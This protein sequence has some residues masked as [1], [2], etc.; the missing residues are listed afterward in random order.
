MAELTAG[1]I[2]RGGRPAIKRECATDEGYGHANRP[3]VRQI[4]AEMREA[5]EYD[6][7]FDYR[8]TGQDNLEPW[9]KRRKFG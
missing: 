3:L 4:V 6:P 5:A 1:I 9:Q 2:I 7:R 8:D